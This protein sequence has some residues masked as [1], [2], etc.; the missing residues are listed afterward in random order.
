MTDNV[1]AQLFTV[2]ADERAALLSADY[3]ALS[4]LAAAKEEYLQGLNRTPPPK[5]V[6]RT[7]KAQISENQGLIAAALRGVDAA[8]RRIAALEDVRDVLTTYDPSGKVT[9]TPTTH[10]TLEKKA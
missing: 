10:K 7:L 8:R 6:L 2:L 1:L 9:Q 4:D 3:G 5:D